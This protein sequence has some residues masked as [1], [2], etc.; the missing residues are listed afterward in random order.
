MPSTPLTGDAFTA[1]KLGRMS[2]LVVEQFQDHMRAGKLNDGD[3][4]PPERDLAA[5]FGVG[6]NTMREAL[7]ELGL[8]GLVT[9]RHGEGTFVTIPSATDLAA[10]FRAVI[11]LS[12]TATDSVMEFRYAFEPG[13]SA[14]AAQVINDDGH[15]ALH[16]ALTQ[17]EL[18]IDNADS[19][20]AAI[21]TA[22]QADMNFH[23]A[24]AHSTGNPIINAVYDAMDSLL[25]GSR[26]QIDSRTYLP[27]SS[28]ARGHRR[29]YEAICAGDPQDAAREMAQH[30]NDVS[31]T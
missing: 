28:Q 31:R 22:H 7:R 3:K 15:T 1:V 16:Q 20:A 12:I 17:F 13:V 27:T 2:R 24:I 19:S 18:C 26:T 8:L 25:S 23:R 29:I 5:M 4:L 9:S 30:L 6:R 14:L 21:L 10:P 11:E